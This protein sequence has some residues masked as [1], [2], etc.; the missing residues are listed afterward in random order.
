MR[1]RRLLPR[2]EAALFLEMAVKDTLSRCTTMEALRSM[3]GALHKASFVSRDTGRP[4]TFS[5]GVLGFV[6]HHHPQDTLPYRLMKL[7]AITDCS[8]H[9]TDVATPRS[10]IWRRRA[11]LLEHGWLSTSARNT[12]PKAWCLWAGV[13]VEIEG[14]GNG[15]THI[16]CNV[17]VGDVLAAS[18]EYQVRKWAVV[19]EGAYDDYAMRGRRLVLRTEGALFLE[20]AVKDTLSQCTTMEA[21]RSMQ[22]ALHK[23]SFVS[24]DAGRPQTCR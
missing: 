21:L 6:S 24:R 23:A 7:N 13:C 18:W 22:G 3:Q 1:G 2:T 14:R 15:T 5:L 10:C 20:M 9:S 16:S 19:V 12:A 4:Q 17:V 11:S 8:N